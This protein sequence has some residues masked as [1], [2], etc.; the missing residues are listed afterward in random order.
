MIGEEV[1]GTVSA[2]YD[3]QNDWGF[4]D[5]AE[6]TGRIFWHV[7]NVIG[8]SLTPGAPVAFVRGKKPDAKGRIRPCALEI[9]RLCNFDMRAGDALEA[10]QPGTPEN[11]EA[12]E[13]AN[14]QDGE[15][16][17]VWS[18][19]GMTSAAGGISSS[20][21]AVPCSVTGPAS[22]TAKHWPLATL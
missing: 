13:G 19:R 17:A 5:F 1:L 7:T 4:I 11:S 16:R 18:P 3:P 20:L 12:G 15:L 9:R 21:T 10:E 8:K 6:W 2:D 14:G 22:S